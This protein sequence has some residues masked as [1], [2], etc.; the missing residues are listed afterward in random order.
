MKRTCLLINKFLET[1]SNKSI[2]KVVLN[3]FYFTFDQFCRKKLQTSYQMNILIKYNV[4][5]LRENCI[6]APTRV[7]NFIFILVFCFFK[8]CTYILFLKQTIN[9]LLFCYQRLLSAINCANLVCKKTFIPLY[10]CP[11][12]YQL[13]ANLPHFDMKIW[14]MVVT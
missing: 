8:V 7:C 3:Y 6:G 2:S 14:N 10:H 5:N 1:N 12:F 4:F 9:L 13:F 11:S